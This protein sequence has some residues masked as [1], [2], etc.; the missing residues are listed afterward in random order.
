[1]VSLDDEM[2][3]TLDIAFHLIG[4]GTGIGNDTKVSSFSLDK[5]THIV[6]AVMRDTKRRDQKVAYLFR[7]A[8]LDDLCHFRSYLLRDAVIA[9]DALMDFPSSIDGYLIVVTE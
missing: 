1:M 9:V 5:E 7:A 4:N 8:L 3:G 6:T 2:M